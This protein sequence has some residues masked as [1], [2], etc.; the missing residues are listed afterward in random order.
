MDVEDVEG[1][2]GWEAGRKIEVQNG[3]LGYRLSFQ[4][5]PRS[6]W[7]LVAHIIEGFFS[8]GDHPFFYMLQVIAPLRDAEPYHVALLF[9]SVTVGDFLFIKIF[10][11]EGDRVSG[12]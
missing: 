5:D 11:G 4:P 3:M 8:Y 7:S 10:L 12:Y 9:F 6:C 1:A 2:G